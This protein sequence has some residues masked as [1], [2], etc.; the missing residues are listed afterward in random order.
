MSMSL[1]SN[2]TA[3]RHT[4]EWEHVEGTKSGMG[5]IAEVSSVNDEDESSSLK[6]DNSKFN[7][8]HI[9]DLFQNCYIL[10]F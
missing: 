9:N 6:N 7:T 10:N 8:Q 2:A 4:D 3:H 1:D 5:A